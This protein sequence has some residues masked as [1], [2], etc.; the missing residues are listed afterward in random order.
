MALPRP[1]LL[2]LL[3]VALC[4]AAFLATRGAQDPGGAVTS[5][6]TPAP[7]A[8]VK[9]AAKPAAKKPAVHKAAAP[10]TAA[11]KPAAK[12][13]DKHQA[14]ATK[15]ATPMDTIRDA[16]KSAVPSKP[17]TSRPAK[18]E[19]AASTAE[20]VRGA[21][22]RGDAVVFFFTR[23]GAA[24]DTGTRGSVQALR[25]VKHVMVVKAGLEDLTAFRPV[26]SGA[27][28]SQVPSV[29]VVHKG[30]KARLIEGYVDRG[31]LRQSIA[32]A[33]R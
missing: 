30:K 8:P 16:A 29:V 9:H 27:G 5:V 7:P 20:R 4:A 1:V 14:A 6:P 18:P 32:D 28:V 17:Q 3:G 33:L 21:L 11:H 31:T 22:A 12:A 24:D 15:P 26:L 10:K 19:P 2:A 13:A 23:A 25:G